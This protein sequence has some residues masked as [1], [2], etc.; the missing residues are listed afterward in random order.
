MGIKE[1]ICSVFGVLTICNFGYRIDK[2]YYVG[3][4]DLHRTYNSGNNFQNPNMAIN[5]NDKTLK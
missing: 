3:A 1:K 5:K 4:Y 2:Q